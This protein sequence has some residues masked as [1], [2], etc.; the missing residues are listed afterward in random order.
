MKY[1]FMYVSYVMFD[2]VCG[3]FLGNLYK[4]KYKEGE[5]ELVPQLWLSKAKK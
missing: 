2:G 4:I 1:G 5:R 3:Y